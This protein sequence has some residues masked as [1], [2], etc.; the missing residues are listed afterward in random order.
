MKKLLVLIG[1]ICLAVMLV[2]S[3][4]AGCAAPT[5]TPTPTPEKEKTL[6]IAGC[7]IGG[8]FY[9]YSTGLMTMINDF[10]PGYRAIAQVT[11]CSGENVRL[12]DSK[13][14]DVAFIGGGTALQGF[15]AMGKFE[16]THSLALLSRLAG[17]Y[18]FWMTG[19]P[20]IK[21]LDDLK[22]KRIAIGDPGSG[23]AIRG[24]ATLEAI[25]FTENDFN[26][27]HLNEQAAADAIKDGTV[28]AWFCSASTTQASIVNL[29]TSKKTYFIS[30]EKYIKAIADHY[31][32]TGDLAA[33]H[34]LPAGTY[35]G[36]DADYTTLITPQVICVHP[37]M[38]E[39]LV[40]AIT[41]AL[42]E[43]MDLMHKIHAGCKEWKIEY[44][45]EPMPIPMH[46]G[47]ERYY[48]EVGTI[49]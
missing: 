29:T 37:D 30:Q 35:K 24:F 39:E 23:T 47:A 38:D 36:M 3:V 16:K 13:K 10:V 49:Q 42:W 28:D 48:K 5:P 34:V 44:N 4:M 8:A 21:T 31:V 41:K 2:V 18:G 27:I 46:P 26:P 9:P 33:P 19:D 12:I 14:V 25:G 40:Y 17:S 7:G 15:K 20:N 32:E 22:G 6:L 11:G 1:S 43:H 45:A